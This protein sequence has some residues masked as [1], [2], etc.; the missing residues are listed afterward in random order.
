MLPDI[1]RA[2]QKFYIFLIVYLT[3][4]T[5]FAEMMQM[6][7]KI[8]DFFSIKVYLRIKIWIQNQISKIINQK[9]KSKTLSKEIG[10]FIYWVWEAGKGKRIY[11][12][13]KT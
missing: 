6:E 10:I 9:R 5:P 12:K 3:G 13:S 1:H 2:T 8:V 4:C 11:D 7:Q